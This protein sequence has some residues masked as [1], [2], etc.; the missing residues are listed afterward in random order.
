MKS[1]PSRH[2]WRLGDDAGTGRRVRG[3]G[4]QLVLAV[5][6]ARAHRCGAL[7][8]H[9][10]C[11]RSALASG[12]YAFVTAFAAGAAAVLS[13]VL[14]DDATDEGPSTLVG[15]ALAFD[16]FAMFVTITICAA[17]AAPRLG[18]RRLPATGR[19]RRTG[20]VRAR[21]RR[22]R[23]RRGDGRGQRPD[24]AVPRARDD[25]A[26]VLRAGGEQPPATGSQESGIKYFVLGGF[27]SAFFLYGI[28]LVYG[29]IGSTN[30]TE[31]VAAFDSTIPVD[32]NDAL[33]PRRH[34]P[35]A[36]RA[37]VQGRRRAVPRVDARRL[38]GRAD[39]GHRADGVG[40]QGGGVRRDAARPR[41]RRCRST[42]TTG[43]RSSGS[44][45]V[46]RWSSARCSPSCRPTSSGCSPTRRST[47]PASCSSA[48]RPRRT[49][50]GRPTAVPA[51][52]A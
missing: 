35:A 51:C 48:S 34:R 41:R 11:T 31:I 14:W 24:R 38:P 2:L 3:T 21:A 1:L 49:G 20:A 44:L 4:D 45:A 15:G 52:R 23:R 17:V 7:P 18:L 13:M 27:S 16:T 42:A 30:I 9:R 6:D 40:R 29:P 25:V 10:R 43:G 12:G 33:R 8:P 39:A 5:P 36:R 37:R 32:R 19:P 50:P 28:A 47:T 22:R 26:G 46:R